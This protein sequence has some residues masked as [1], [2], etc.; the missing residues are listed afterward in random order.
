M[1]R[2]APGIWS[3][4]VE[5]RHTIQIHEDGGAEEAQVEHGHQALPAREDLDVR[6]ATAQELHDVRKRVR[7][8]V[9]ERGG[10]QERAGGR[11]AAKASETFASAD[12]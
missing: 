5:A 8:H 6:V 7:P 10:L 11:P 1:V 2:A 3:D 12:L 4:T 9:S